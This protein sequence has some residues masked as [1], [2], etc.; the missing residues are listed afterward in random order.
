MSNHDRMNINTSFLFDDKDERSLEKNH[1]HFLLLD[2]GKYQSSYL[3][4]ET[5]AQ[6]RALFSQRSFSYE[7]N[8]DHQRGSSETNL[9]H[10]SISIESLDNSYK[11]GSPPLERQSGFATTTKY[12]KEMQRVDFVSC[13]CETHNSEHFI[14]NTLLYLNFINYRLCSYYHR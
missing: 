12:P 7:G 9:F 3:D 6:S 1:T 8:Q 2:D 13:A 4:N 11:P 5:N 14:S 10:Q